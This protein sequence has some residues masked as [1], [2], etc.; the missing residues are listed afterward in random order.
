MP[1]RSTLAGAIGVAHNCPG[2][3]FSYGLLAHTDLREANLRGATLQHT[4]LY[5]ANLKDAD[6]REIHCGEHPWLPLTY[7][8]YA[9]AW[10]PR[11]P[12]L[13]V[14]QWN[15]IKLWD[16]NTGQPIG[17]PLE[18]HQLL[19]TSVAFSPDGRWLASGSWGHTV[20]LWDTTTQMGTG[21][22]TGHLSCVTSVAFNH[23]GQLL[24]SG[25]TDKTVR[26]WDVATQDWWVKPKGIRR[27]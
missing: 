8:A 20:R 26:L 27:E 7:A 10:H 23:D 2:R 11:Q 9:I 6:L 1:T 25:S 16:S 21:Q 19:V 5:R 18:G 12:W 24:A 3:I 22:L 13:A 15:T 17:Q 14:S 4:I